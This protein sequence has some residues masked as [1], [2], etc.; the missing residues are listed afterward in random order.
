MM[1]Y[2]KLQKDAKFMKLIQ[3]REV[4]I[5][6]PQT[7]AANVRIRKWLS[8]PYF[9]E[10]FCMTDWDGTRIRVNGVVPSPRRG[11][12]FKGTLGRQQICDWFDWR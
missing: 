1:L 12:T 2:D 4:S 9:A 5:R 6:S 8:L 11:G 3:E 7:D 10:I